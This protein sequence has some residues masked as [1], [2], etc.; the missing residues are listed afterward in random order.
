LIVDG[1]TWLHVVDLSDGTTGWIYQGV[2]SL[3]TPVPNW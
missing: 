3:A 2:V 1:D